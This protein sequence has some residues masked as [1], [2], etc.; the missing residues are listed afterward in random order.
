M[1]TL[2]DFA[3]RPARPEDEETVLRWRNSDQVRPYMLNQV[4]ISVAEHHAW[5][6]M[7]FDQNRP[8]R[9]VLEHDHDPLGFV[10]F[11][12]LDGDEWDWSI[13]VGEPDSPRGTGTAL[14]ILALDIAFLSLDV[15]L[16]RSAVFP[17]NERAIRL[18]S[19]LTFNDAV[20]PPFQ[21]HPRSYSQKMRQFCLNRTDWFANRDE[22]LGRFLQLLK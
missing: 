6:A 16:L 15:Q 21:L 9:F 22:V 13:Y 20:D 7:G 19:R 8:S 3:L 12:H 18:Y 11:T 14:G 1:R 5:F 10:H 2:A 4:L 17:T